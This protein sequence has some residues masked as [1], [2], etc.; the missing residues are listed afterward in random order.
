[1]SDE[2]LM[3]ALSQRAQI[4]QGQVFISGFPCICKCI[5]GWCSER[6][7]L[8]VSRTQGYSWER[9][10]VCIYVCVAAGLSEELRAC[11]FMYVSL[12]LFVGMSGAL[13]QVSLCHGSRLH[14]QTCTR[15]HTGIRKKRQDR[16]HRR[17]CAPRRGEG[18]FP[19]NRAKKKSMQ[20]RSTLW[21]RPSPL[22]HRC[23]RGEQQIHLTA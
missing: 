1:M 2:Y 10:S 12:W 21:L 11:V 15:T 7:F 13:Q 5:V 23:A 18:P 9:V 22:K 17:R 4:K 19:N 16:A 8:Q 20:H 14:T 6:R 3:C